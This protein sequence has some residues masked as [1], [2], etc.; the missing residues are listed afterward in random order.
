MVEDG[1]INHGRQQLKGRNRANKL[2]FFP[3]PEDR[4]G[5]EWEYQVGDMVN[6]RIERATAWSLQ[7]SAV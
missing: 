6:V 7:G 5:K 3:Q 4:K 2:V 1:N